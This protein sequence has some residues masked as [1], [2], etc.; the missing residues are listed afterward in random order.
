[1][2]ALLL[3]AA[4]VL[5]AR[6]SSAQDPL[7]AAKRAS[8]NA[9]ASTNQHTNAMQR[10]EAEPA[11][12]PAPAA[13][14][15]QSRTEAAPAANTSRPGAQVTTGSP[16]TAGPPPSILR[17]VYDYAKDGRRDPFVSLLTTAELRPTMSDLRLTSVLLDLTGR[18][19]VAILRDLATNA[20]HRVHVGSTLGRMR[21]TAIR[22]GTVLM[23]IDEFGMTRQDSL[24]L[25]DST[26]VRK[27]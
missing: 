10:P 13:K 11:T 2:R 7:S 12:K 23:T 17:E 20:Q 14:A 1:M 24:V 4:L 18:N 19:S 25:R 26:K 5:A 21:V 22:S 3:T 9:V 16:D 15:Q 8:Q 27:P 6:P